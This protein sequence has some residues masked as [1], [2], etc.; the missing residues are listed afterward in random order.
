MKI[1]TPTLTLKRT[2]YVVEPNTC[3][4]MYVHPG[5]ICTGKDTHSYQLYTMDMK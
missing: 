1:K 2:K 3:N 4:Y 5:V